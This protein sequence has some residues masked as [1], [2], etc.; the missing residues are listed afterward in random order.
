MIFFLRASFFLCF[1]GCL[2][3]LS[4]SLV[5]AEPRYLVGSERS[6]DVLNVLH[7]IRVPYEERTE[8]PRGERS[9]TFC[10]LPMEKRLLPQRIS[11]PRLCSRISTLLPPSLTTL[12]TKGRPEPTA[13]THQQQTTITMAP[14]LV[15]TYFDMGGTA[16]MIRFALELG[17]LEWEDRRLSQDE[18][19]AL[20]P[21]EYNCCGIIVVLL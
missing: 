5:T 11:F 21:S 9:V 14:K 18:F 1:F 6:W 4:L 3:S 17:G 16:D 7:H 12:H 10:A 20:K 13:K 2:S 15:L 19:A 8:Q